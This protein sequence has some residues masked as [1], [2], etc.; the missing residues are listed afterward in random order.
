MTDHTESEQAT[1]V[2]ATT[3]PKD[4]PDHWAP[5]SIW[6]TD[7]TAHNFHYGEC[8]A[9]R[10]A[11]ELLVELLFGGAIT[12]GDWC[13]TYDDDGEGRFWLRTVSGGVEIKHNFHDASYWGR[14]SYG[15]KQI[16]GYREHD[17]SPVV[18]YTAS[19]D[20]LEQNAPR[21][22]AV[23]REVAKHD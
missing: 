5:S 13:L 18:A 23:L 8:F 21:I 4:R 2:Q 12:D 22:A 1:D 3:D 20:N 6:E 15:L 19:F 17:R 11:G 9:R 10:D 14:G 7:Q 16:V